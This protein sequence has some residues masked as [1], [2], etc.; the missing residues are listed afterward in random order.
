[1]FKLSYNPGGKLLFKPLSTAV[2][3]IA[4]DKNIKDNLSEFEKKFR[5]K[6]SELHR[7]NFFLKRISR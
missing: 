1:M 6:L 3:Y 5:I 2:Y 7:K 4:E